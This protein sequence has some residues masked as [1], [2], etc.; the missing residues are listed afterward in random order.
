[1]SRTNTRGLSIMKRS[2]RSQTRPGQ[3]PF[4]GALITV[5]PLPVARTQCLLAGETILWPSMQRGFCSSKLYPRQPRGCA[6]YWPTK[7]LP[8][9]EREAAARSGRDRQLSEREAKAAP[10]S[11][12]SCLRFRGVCFGRKAQLYVGERND[13][14]T[15]SEREELTRLRGRLQTAS[16]RGADPARVATGRSRQSKG[17]GKSPDD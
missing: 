7:P 11:Y 10:K 12:W 13:G 3:T 6:G 4:G 1:M 15:S 17:L 5:P 16:Q 14:L 2:R 8:C 9:A